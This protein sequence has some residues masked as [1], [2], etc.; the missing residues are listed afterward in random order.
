VKNMD[1][2]IREVLDAHGRLNTAPNSLADDVNLYEHG[3]TS[4]ASVNVMLALENAFG[5]EFPDSLL[6]KSTFQS[7]DAMRESL[8]SMGVTAD[9]F[10]SG[11]K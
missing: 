3:L 10:V 2:V 7:V 11:E 6:R 5:Q 4:H 8:L 9:E 1:E